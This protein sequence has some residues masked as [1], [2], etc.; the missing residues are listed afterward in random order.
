[1]KLEYNIYIKANKEKLW[2]ILTDEEETK[3][4]YYGASLISNFGI[5][6]ELKYVGPG[7]EGDKTLHMYGSVLE[8][9]INEVF[10]H[11]II[12]GSAYNV[13]EEFESRITFKI[14]ELKHF[15]KLEVIHDNWNEKDPS[16]NNTK[17]NWWLLLSNIKT[18]AETGKALEIGFH[19]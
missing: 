14:I 12:V 5:G 17:A 16:Y 2:K 9:K 8:Y 15:L 6:S 10:S 18:L 7:R 3:K 11:N 4:I 13:G 1:M 19:E